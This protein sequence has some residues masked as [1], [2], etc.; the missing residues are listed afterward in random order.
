MEGVTKDDFAREMLD[1]EIAAGHFI[2]TEDGR[3]RE[4]EPRRAG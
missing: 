1:R 2:L 4:P 3:V